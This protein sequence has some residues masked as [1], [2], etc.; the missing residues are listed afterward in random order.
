MVAFLAR[1]RKLKKKVQKLSAKKASSHKHPIFARI[2]DNQYWQRQCDKARELQETV[3]EY[4]K[5]FDDIPIFSPEYTEAGR[6][7]AFM[8]DE[9]SGYPMRP[10]RVLKV[11][12]IS[13]DIDFN[14]EEP[15]DMSY[16]MQQPQ[17]WSQPHFV[18]PRDKHPIFDD[19]TRPELLPNNPFYLTKEEWE[20]LQ[21]EVVVVDE[22]EFS[23]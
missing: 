1:L 17:L 4:E 8:M 21:Q 23:F 19:K 11:T 20:R 6:L 9:L 3:L 16:K 2:Q 14:G 12:D 7:L 18:D 5:I 15:A 10:P 13:W 22:D